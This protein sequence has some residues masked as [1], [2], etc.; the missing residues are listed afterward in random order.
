M[1]LAE[2]S[3]EIFPKHKGYFLISKSFALSEYIFVALTKKLLLPF[4]AGLNKILYLI[5]KN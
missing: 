5:L 3:P 2:K 1:L 4:N